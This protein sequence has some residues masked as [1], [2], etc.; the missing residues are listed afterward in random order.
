[1]FA[2]LLAGALLAR[3]WRIGSLFLVMAA[4]P[5]IAAAFVPLTNL[6]FGRTL[7][8]RPADSVLA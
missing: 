4:C 7:A 6:A 1:M 8:P 2:P 5:V 3:G